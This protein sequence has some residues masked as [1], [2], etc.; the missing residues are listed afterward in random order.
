MNIFQLTV[1][2]QKK[3]TE[4]ILNF[5]VMDGQPLLVVGDKGFQLL[6]SHLEPRYDM[7]SRK[8]MSET[9]LP[10]L[11]GKVCKDISEKIKDVSSEFHNRY[12]E[13]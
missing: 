6:I 1:C 8:Y 13:L 9:A 10:E 11:Y 2:R 12:L 3:I 4:R 7:V 5:I